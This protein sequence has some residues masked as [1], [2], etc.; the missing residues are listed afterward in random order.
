VSCSG[1]KRGRSLQSEERAKLFRQ[2]LSAEF[3]RLRWA[4]SATKH[5]ISKQRIL[6]VLEH[7]L[8]IRKEDPHPGNPRAK[9]P[10]LV[11]LGEDSAGVP[12]EVIAVRT[13]RANLMVIHAMNL[14]PR[15]R[16]LYEEVRRWDR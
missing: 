9:A 4:R 11:F 5:R 1:P 13:N 3:K 10:R 6:H 16:P 12:L 15:Y 7:C 14:R 8:A 2:N